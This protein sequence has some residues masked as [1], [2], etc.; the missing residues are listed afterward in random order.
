MHVHTYNKYN[1]IK[2]HKINTLRGVKSQRKEVGFKK[3]FKMR[4]RGGLSNV[5]RQTIPKLWS[6]TSKRSVPS[7]LKPSF[8]HCQEQLVS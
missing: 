6:C 8:R 1:H 7:E 4:Q 5:Q 3:S 2:T